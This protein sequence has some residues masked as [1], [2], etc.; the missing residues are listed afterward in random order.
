MLQHLVD[1][2]ALMAC[3]AFYS[4]LAPEFL[5]SK[6]MEWTAIFRYERFESVKIGEPNDILRV[7][8]QEKCSA[9][10]RS[11]P[12]G[13]EV[14]HS[15]FR[16]FDR[17]GCSIEYVHAADKIN[18]WACMHSAAATACRITV[19]SKYILHNLFAPNW[20]NI[21]LKRELEAFARRSFA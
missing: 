14:F 7:V 9:Q 8:M 5:V 18:L 6:P 13:F 17:I 12:F 19:R 16:S 20:H 21:N 1:L 4:Y 10:W 15:T 2:N 3:T 11:E